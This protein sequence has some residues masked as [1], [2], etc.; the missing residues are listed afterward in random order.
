[1]TMSLMKSG[2]VIRH[3]TGLSEKNVLDFCIAEETDNQKLQ[4]TKSADPS[5]RYTA[6]LL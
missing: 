3:S 5:F 4:N 1:M 6:L 2:T